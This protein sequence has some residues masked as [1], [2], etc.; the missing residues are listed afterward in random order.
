MVVS[1]VYSFQS[2]I[3]LLILTRIAGLI[4]ILQGLFMWII[5]IGYSLICGYNGNKLLV[6]ILLSVYRGG[7]GIED[8][9]QGD[10]KKVD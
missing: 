6:L 2:A 3:L 1:I 7:D 8:V 9:I 10:I 5:C 4:H